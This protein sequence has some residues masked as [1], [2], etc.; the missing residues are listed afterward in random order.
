[1]ARNI[2]RAG[3][4]H[5]GREARAEDKDAYKCVREHE[6]HTV[7][8]KHTQMAGGRGTHLSTLIAFTVFI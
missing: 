6:A 4:A 3:G 2:Q 5:S 7:G 8:N 1:M